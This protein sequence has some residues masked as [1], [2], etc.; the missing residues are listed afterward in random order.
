MCFFGSRP[1]YN[2]Y[3][4]WMIWNIWSLWIMFCFISISVI[5]KINYLCLLSISVL[6]TFPALGAILLTS[7]VSTLCASL[8][9]LSCDFNMISL[10]NKQSLWSLNLSIFYDA[11]LLLHTFYYTLLLAFLLLLP[12]PIK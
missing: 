4:V 11:L 1:S 5:I 2:K 3:F 12:L 10:F 8:L 7:S 9:N 6:Y